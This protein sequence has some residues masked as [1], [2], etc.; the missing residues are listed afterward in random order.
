[1]TDAIL[2]QQQA[3]EIFDYNPET[4]LFF[5]KQ[6]KQGRRINKVAGCA[7]PDGYIIVRFNKKNFRAHRLAWIY[8]HG[9]IPN[10]MYIDHVN[11]DRSDNRISNLRLVDALGN[12]LN[13]KQQRKKFE[14][15]S[16]S[17]HKAIAANKILEAGKVLG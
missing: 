9:D 16:K 14:P 17:S 7:I 2:I 11:R 6:G 4:G 8:M 15:R 13:R 12:C 5:W 1:M 3:H 10:G